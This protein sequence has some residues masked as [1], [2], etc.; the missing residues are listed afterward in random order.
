[1]YLPAA[2]QSRF[3]WQS[4]TEGV[5]VVSRVLSRVVLRVVSVH[6]V[7]APRPPPVCPC[8]CPA[9]VRRHKTGA[10]LL[11]RSHHAG[12]QRPSR[13]RSAALPSLWQNRS[14]AAAG[15]RTPGHQPLGPAP[16]CPVR[17][18][19]RSLFTSAEGKDRGTEGKSACRG[20]AADITT[21]GQRRSSGRARRSGANGW[22]NAWLPGQV[23]G[24]LNAWSNTRIPVGSAGAGRA[25]FPRPDRSGR[26]GESNSAPFSPTFSARTPSPHNKRGL[27]A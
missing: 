26:A 13:S 2:G 1:M 25:R 8:A 12:V 7:T 15:S 22:L 3:F 18:S 20:S 19:V 10:R 24:W 5:R 14:V 4:C 21:A 6:P 9:D 17:S 11:P 16:R 27:G 23:N